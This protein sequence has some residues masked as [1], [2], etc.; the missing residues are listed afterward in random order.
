MLL[1]NLHLPHQWQVV[2][3]V[4]WCLTSIGKDGTQFLLKG[5]A[6][7]SSSS[8]DGG[9]GTTAGG[10]VDS[11]AGVAEAQ[12]VLLNIISSIESV[13]RIHPLVCAQANE[14]IGKNFLYIV[15]NCPSNDINTSSTIIIINYVHEWYIYV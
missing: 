6:G 2:E 8:L 12:S 13:G 10:A 14:F 3:S 5:G 9:D 15:S 1:L 7:G 11:A 4:F